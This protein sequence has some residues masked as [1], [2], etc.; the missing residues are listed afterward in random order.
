MVHL[1]DQFYYILEKIGCLKYISVIIID[2]FLFSASFH[3]Y[4]DIFDPPPPDLTDRFQKFYPS[5]SYSMDIKKQNSMKNIEDIE[6]PTPLTS[7]TGLLVIRELGNVS[8]FTKSGR[9][10]KT[11]IAFDWLI[12]GPYFIYEK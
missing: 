4:F 3:P 12:S 6:I 7:D 5:D 10:T 9:L 1:S 11:R 2:V 8:T